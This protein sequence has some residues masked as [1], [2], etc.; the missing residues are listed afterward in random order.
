MVGVTVAGGCNSK[1][2]M[3][4][5]LLETVTLSPSTLRGSPRS[6]TLF[7]GAA[8]QAA[9]GAASM[10]GLLATRA[11][12]CTFVPGG[13]PAS[14]LVSLSARV[15]SRML[16]RATLSPSEVASMSPPPVLGEKY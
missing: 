15:L 4:H 1:A 13:L 6:S 10:A 5:S 7:T 9:L 2:P 16:P 8:V 12:V 11:R 3:S 14:T